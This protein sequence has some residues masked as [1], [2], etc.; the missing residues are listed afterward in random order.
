M[1]N[2]TATPSIHA[3]DA[4]REHTVSVTFRTVDAVGHAGVTVDPEP[5]ENGVL[6]HLVEAAIVRLVAWRRDFL[7]AEAADV[8]AQPA[9]LPRLHADW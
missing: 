4:W 6:L 2:P 5:L 7:E 1:I 8:C 3:L 9:R